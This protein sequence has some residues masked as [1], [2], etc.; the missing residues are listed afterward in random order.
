M[1]SWQVTLVENAQQAFGMMALAP[2]SR[3]SVGMVLMWESHTQMTAEA[4]EKHELQVSS[5]PLV[6][7]LQFQIMLLSSIL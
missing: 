2:E 7:Q 3:G 1:R 6:A 5:E 4:L